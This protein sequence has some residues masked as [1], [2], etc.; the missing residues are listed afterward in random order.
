V[1]RIL[2]IALGSSF[3]QQTFVSIGKVLPAVLAPVIIAELA[4]DPSW[5]GVYFGL[6][7]IFALMAQMGCG[8]FIMRYGPLRMSQV[9]LA[10]LAVGMLCMTGGWKT[11]FLLSA[12]IG[13][14]GA[15]ISTPTSSQLLGKMS[16][17]RLAPL[18]FS[19]RQTGVPMGLMLGG[20]FG[21][22]L[23]QS[24]GW[25]GTVIASAVACLV[26]AI[27]LQPLR[28]WFDVELAPGRRFKFS[29]FGATLRSVI[30]NPGLRNLAFAC[31]AFNGMQQVMTSYFVIYLTSI[32]YDLVA[33]GYIFSCAVAVAIPGRILWGWLGSFHVEPRLVMAGI[34]LGIAAGATGLGFFSAQWPLVAI[35]AMSVLLSLTALSWHGILLSESARLAPIGMTGSV[36]GGVL[37]FGQMGALLGPLVYAG[38]LRTTGSY[39]IGFVVCGL[40]SLFVGLGLLRQKTT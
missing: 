23:A 36:A 21:P 18:M 20:A 15:A 35:G 12:L 7:S 16:P 38:L 9:A 31:F 26:F 6:T 10:M 27:L 24:M 19:I 25:R 17:P 30:A 40:P 29:D 28:P 34:A 22:T 3:L 33:A 4:Y 11:F 39:G 13:G 5:V 37:S 1:N 32:G 8:S 2:L 14:S